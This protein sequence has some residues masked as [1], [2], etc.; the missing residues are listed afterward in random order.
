MRYSLKLL[1]HQFQS[2]FV[3]TKKKYMAESQNI[4]MMKHF[5]FTRSLH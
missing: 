4:D 2:T 5:L 3:K 1:K